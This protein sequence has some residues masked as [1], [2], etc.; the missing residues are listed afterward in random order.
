[1]V[2]A[3]LAFGR[4]EAETEETVAMDL[5]ELLQGIVGETKK[6]SIVGLG[7]SAAVVARIRPVALNTAVQYGGQAKVGLSCETDSAIITISDNGPGL[8]EDQLGAVFEPFRRFETSRNRETGGTGLGLAIARTV[9][10]GHGG[11]VTLRNRRNGGLLATVEL[12]L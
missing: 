2:E 3:T 7:E 4:G 5:S 1:M 9:I 6:A 11:E 8:P 12:P 10:R